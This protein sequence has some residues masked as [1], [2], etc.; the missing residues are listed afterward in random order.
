MSLVTEG[1]AVGFSIAAP[2]GAIGLLCIEHTING[3]IRR[4]I[5]AGLGA[6]TADML[7]GV[8][9]ALGF[10]A[11]QTTLLEYKA[12]LTVMGGLFLCYL[13]IKKFFSSPKKAV[14]RPLSGG[15]LAAFVVTFFLTLTN[16]ATILDFMALFTGLNINMSGFMESLSFVAGVFLGSALWWCIL[17]F[18]VNAF[19]VKITTQIL[20]Y[21]NY[22]AGIVI[23]GFGVY[24]LSKLWN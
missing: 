9:V 5:A 22:V 19:R 13:G 7:Y 4:G 20:K 14:A 1:I 11:L 21:I 18:V 12:P 17:C 2:V 6:A 16:P 10:T 3:G 8:L 23:F 15:L 24:A